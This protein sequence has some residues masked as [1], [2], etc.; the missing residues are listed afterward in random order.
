MKIKAAI[1]G[2]S[3]YTGQQLLSILSNHN[4]VT[5]EAI[6]GSNSVG[7]RVGDLLPITNYA[8]D[9]EILDSSNFDF[10]S[11]DVVFSCL[12][13]RTL[14]KT[15]ENINS[16]R[17]I[18]LSADFRFSSA[19]KYE[20]YYD[21]SHQNPKLLEKFVYG[22]SEINEELIRNSHF[23]ANPGCYPTSILI[24]LIPILNRT[25]NDVS[26]MIDAKS[27]MSGAGKTFVESN[28]FV[29]I[30]E[31]LKPYKIFTHQHQPEIMEQL[32]K[33]NQSFDLTFVPH[34]I[35]ISRGI[36]STIY[37]KNVKEKYSILRK[38]LEDTFKNS[39]FVKILPIGIIPNI[40]NVLGT[41]NISINIFED[42]L[43]DTVVIISV[44]DNLIKG[45]A[46][47]AVQNMNLMY[48][49]NV[50]ESLKKISMI[51]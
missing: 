21:F 28:L 26:I 48:N 20:D 23:I 1:L 32:E 9:I 50:S 49:L 47:Q 41:N 16:K 45:A 46:G 18:D 24:P 5:I 4:K 34:L 7:K 10:S 33:N 15:V 25:N 29:E 51:P 38:I 12:P 6:F 14:H 13:H 2:V 39:S 11:I 3:G 8:S 44:I 43:S 30:N 17:I 37:L 42:T 31:N 36:L 27:G 40:K 35:P 19:K 22:L